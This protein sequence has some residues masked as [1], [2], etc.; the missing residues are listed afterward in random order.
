MKKELL[1]LFVYSLS[2]YQLL[3]NNAHLLVQSVGEGAIAVFN[4]STKDPL[5]KGNFIPQNIRISVR[6][7]SGIETISTGFQCRFGAESKFLINSDGLEL[8]EASLLIRA[9]KFENE[10]RI[11][12]SGYETV[13]S[14]I[15]TCLLETQQSGGFKFIGLTGKLRITSSNLNKS[16]SLLPGS[17]FF[18]K[19]QGEGFSQ[20]V[21]ISLL[22]LLNS[23]FLIQGFYNSKSFMKA[24]Q[25]TSLAQA[26]IVIS[27]V[28]AQVGESKKDGLF[29]VMPT[30]K[31]ATIESNK[32]NVTRIDSF[33]ND[34]LT[35][36]LG[37]K[38][39]RMT[40]PV[41]ENLNSKSESINLPK[42]TIPEIDF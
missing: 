1:L 17:L 19:P 34:P 7:K 31:H 27:E 18:L 16:I 41:S 4:G 11:I 42:I 30:N 9:R 29:E 32:S 3:A 26:D 15:G 36:L 37:R 21:N 40:I 25:T 38:P 12:E 13:L 39:K 35:E 6:P 23:S 33:S 20:E 10:I 5:K 22:E 24:L 28:G 14:G 2:S 8:I